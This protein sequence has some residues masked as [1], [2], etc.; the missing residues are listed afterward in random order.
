MGFLTDKS[1]Q[2]M[3]KPSR[4]RKNYQTIQ[5]ELVENI[6]RLLSTS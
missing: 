1:D 3:R 6:S 5:L 4:Y 2:N